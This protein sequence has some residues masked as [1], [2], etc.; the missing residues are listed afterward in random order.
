MLYGNL[1]GDISAFYDKAYFGARE[2]ERL[3][4]QRRGINVLARKMR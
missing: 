1:I 4:I 2:T 3:V